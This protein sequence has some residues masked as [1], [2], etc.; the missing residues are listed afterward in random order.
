VKPR[1]LLD[2]ARRKGVER[3][4]ITDHNEIW[5]AQEAQQ[6]DPERVMWEEVLTTKG[7]LLR[8]L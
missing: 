8:F 1:D 4:A 5:A 3:L 7:E 2:E 6:L